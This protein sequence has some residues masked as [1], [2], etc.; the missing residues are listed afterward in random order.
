[1]SV[2][3]KLL[4]NFTV[5]GLIGFSSEYD[6]GNSGSAITVDFAN[7]Q[8]QKVT[9]NNATPTIT[10]ADGIAVGHYQLKV[11]QD[12]AGGRTPSYAGSNYS[13]SRW[14]GSSSAPAVLTTSAAESLITMYWDGS[15]WY[16]AMNHVGA[17]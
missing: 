16:Q 7:G 10:F 11:I 15:K 8:K 14:I 6:N 12:G 17:T 5:D 1:M 4:F 3:K 13:G 9:L 2:L